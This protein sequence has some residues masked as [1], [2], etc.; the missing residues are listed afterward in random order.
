MVTSGSPSAVTE[1][2]TR[3]RSRR[4]SSGGPRATWLAALVLLASLTA[5]FAEQNAKCSR[6][7][8]WVK[9]SDEGFGFLREWDGLCGDCR[10][11][12]KRC[13]DALKDLERRLEEARDRLGFY[14]MSLRWAQQ[15][16][17][18][19]AAEQAAYQRENGVSPQEDVRYWSWHVDDQQKVVA[20]LADLLAKMKA[21]CSGTAAGGTAPGGG[22]DP[23][24]APGAADDLA[25]TVRDLRTQV[26]QMS[27]L[28]KRLNDQV[29]ALEQQLGPPADLS[30]S[31]A[32]IEASQLDRAERYLAPL[33]EEAKGG[34]G[35]TAS[36]ATS[37]EQGSGPVVSQ[38]EVVKPAL[39]DL[40]AD[41]PQ[42][43]V[44][45]Q[46]EMWRRQTANA[47]AYAQAMRDSLAQVDAA[48]A[49]GDAKRAHLHRDR[50]AF[51]ASAGQKALRQAEAA[52]TAAFRKLYADARAFGARVKEA[53]TTLEERLAAWQAKVRTEGLPTDYVANL[54]SAGLTDAQIAKHREA[55]QGVS[56]A[57]AAATT[58]RF[59]RAAAP[60][61]LSEAR[62]GQPDAKP[63]PASDELWDLVSL[64]VLRTGEAK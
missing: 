47:A 37:G 60:L 18:G 28:A 43:T 35:A 20:R 42:P 63:L 14:R 51:L 30:A 5:A 59:L 6:C 23:G 31:S 2:D 52:R 46:L 9:V 55:L 61:V 27:D 41:L 33:V 40:D 64:R 12:G 45:R 17:A 29:R 10:D 53:G 39:V 1:R 36:E 11:P 54:R 26:E 57:K 50:T 32:P 48:E 38:A 22:P 58:A 4:R 7:G 21:E 16:A 49:A 3:V 44:P 56:A 13:D 8:N 19:D 25:D 15:A 24:G 62:E 34:R